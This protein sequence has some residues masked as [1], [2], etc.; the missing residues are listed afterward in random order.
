MR[1]KT[2]ESSCETSPIDSDVLPLTLTLSPKRERGQKR[3]SLTGYLCTI[4]ADPCGVFQFDNL[5]TFAERVTP[6]LMERE[7]ENCFLLGRLCELATARE[8]G[9]DSMWSVEADDGRVVAAALMSP[10]RDSIRQHPLVV[11]RASADAIGTL[12]DHLLAGTRR[13]ARRQRAEPTA[14]EFADAWC[15]GTGRGRRVCRRAR[16]APADARRAAAANRRTVPRGDGERIRGPRLLGGGILPGRQRARVAGFLRE[17]RRQPDPRGAAVALVR[18]A[19]GLDGRVVGKD[20]ERGAGELCIFAGRAPRPRLRVGVRRG[21]E[22]GTARLG[23]KVL[24]PVH[25]PGQP[26]V[27]QD[28][29][30]R[31]LRAG[32]QLQARRLPLASFTTERHGGALDD[33]G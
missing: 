11:T 13:P 8:D 29:Q 28:L 12:I 9:S 5:S 21:P 31:R 17:N 15:A 16:T 25:R 2:R 24:H 7:A 33:R 20:A 27:E 30:V 26:D 32:L 4:R 1:G 14:D 23:A 18:P 19:P 10:R 3:D 6:L 22:P